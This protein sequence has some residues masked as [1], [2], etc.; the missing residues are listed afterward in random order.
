MSLFGKWLTVKIQYEFRNNNYTDCEPESDN[1]NYLRGTRLFKLKNIIKYTVCIINI[2]LLNDRIIISTVEYYWIAIVLMCAWTDAAV[3][4]WCTMT[5]TQKWVGKSWRKL[6]AGFLIKC[7]FILQFSP[8]SKISGES[9]AL[10]PS[11][12]AGSIYDRE[13]IFLLL[14][15]YLFL[16]WPLLCLCFCRSVEVCAWVHAVSNKGTVAVLWEPKCMTA[17][18]RPQGRRGRLLRAWNIEL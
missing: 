5:S 17:T 15:I 8:S 6:V 2:C 9:I 12:E 4:A 13:F 3:T 11:I 18:L 7:S 16:W 1:G 10:M 14:F